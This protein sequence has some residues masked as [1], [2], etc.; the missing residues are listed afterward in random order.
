MKSIENQLHLK[1][2]LYC[3]QLKKRIFIGDHMNNYTKLLADLTNMDE[4]IKGED[5]ALIFLSSLSDEKYE[6]FVVSLINGK[7]SLSY[8]DV[9]TALVSLEVRKDKEF[10]FSNTTAEVLSV[11]GISSNHRKR[12]KDFEKFKTGYPE[13]LKKNQ[14][15]F[16]K[17]DGH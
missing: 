3:F 16:C 6:T 10:S 4:V 9:S 8:N 1:R 11:R 15:A 12:K 13:D 2:K 17:E 14:C 7:A 5:K